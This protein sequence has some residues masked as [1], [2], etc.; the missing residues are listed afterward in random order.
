MTGDRR[1]K[2]LE[3]NPIECFVWNK[4]NALNNEYIHECYKRFSIPCM[5]EKDGYK[6]KVDRIDNPSHYLYY[7]EY[8]GEEI[9][10]NL[11][12]KRL[13]LVFDFNESK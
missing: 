9:G 6:Y 4:D 1:D 2:L 5:F 7:I 8:D 13:Q 12:R 10:A 11:D 3:D